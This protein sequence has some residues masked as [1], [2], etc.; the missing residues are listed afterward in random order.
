MYINKD[1]EKTICW[2]NRNSANNADRK[3][4]SP[5]VQDCIYKMVIYRGEVGVGGGDKE[6]EA[7]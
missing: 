4:K 7:Q 6:Y 2:K 5:T 1:K 3:K